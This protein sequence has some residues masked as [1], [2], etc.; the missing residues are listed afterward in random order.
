MPL[1]IMLILVASALFTTLSVVLLTGRGAF[2]VLGYAMLSKEEKEKY[3][4]KA[5]CKFAGKIILPLA[6]A[7]PL[8][9]IGN[10]LIAPLYLMFALGLMAYAA[11]YIN[12]PKGNRFR[13]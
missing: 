5:L 3:D 12:Y 7:T 1:H 4:S 8:L 11:A 10:V 2:F 13:K 6:L 9:A